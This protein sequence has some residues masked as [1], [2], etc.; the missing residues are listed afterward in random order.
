MCGVTGASL[1]ALPLP[2]DEVGAAVAAA[3]G[4]WVGPLPTSECPTFPPPTPSL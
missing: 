4:V 2:P 1:P 3:P